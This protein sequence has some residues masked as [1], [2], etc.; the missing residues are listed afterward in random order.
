MA[1]ERQHQDVDG[2]ADRLSSS[3]SICSIAA[4]RLAVP[5]RGVPSVAPPN[6]QPPA[7]RVGWPTALPPLHDHR[8]GRVFQRVRA[9]DRAER[10]RSARGT[11]DHE[12]RREAN[13]T[14]ERTSE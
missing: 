8:N 13:A 14:G 6:V 5:R 9:Q 10:P 3:S 11:E 4:P 1:E 2:L 12:R 7:D